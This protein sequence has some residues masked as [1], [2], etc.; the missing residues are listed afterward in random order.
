MRRTARSVLVAVALLLLPG[1]IVA[2]EALFVWPLA[3]PVMK[4]WRAKDNCTLEHVQDG[5]GALRWRTEFGRFNF[6]WTT[7]HLAPKL[8]F[9]DAGAV[10]FKVRGDGSGHF[11]SLQLGYTERGKRS[12]YYVNKADGVV[13]DFAE[14]R[15]VS[16]SLARFSPPTGRD[17]RADMTQVAFIEFFV[18][19]KGKGSRTDLML[20]DV[21]VLKAPPE[22]AAELTQLWGMF[23]EMGRQSPAS[24][25]SNVLPNSGFEVE[26]N[27]DGLPDLWRCGDWNT[28]SKTAWDTDVAH[29]G[30]ASVRITCSTDKQRGSFAFRPV[31]GPGPWLFE[32]HC[33]ADDAMKTD[34]RNGP[35]ARLI[36]VNEKGDQ[37]G[38]FHARGGVGDGQWQKVAVAFEL[39]PGAKHI[40]LD[41]F[42]LFAAGSVWWDDVSLRF[43]TV[44]A[45]RQEEERRL[46]AQRAEEAGGMLEGVTALVTALP[47][48]A[49][50][51]KLKKAALM[52]ALEDA[53][54]SLEA[55]LGTEAVTTLTGLKQ[56]TGRAIGRRVDPPAELMFPMPGLA[57]NPYAQG[58]IGRAASVLRSKTLYKKGD[59]GYSQVS[60]AWSFSTMGNNVYAATWGLCYPESPHAAD[61]ELLIRVLRLLQAIFQNHRDGD[62]NPGREAVHGR[63]PNINRFCFV[64]TFEAYLLLTATYPDLLLP[65]KRAE[66]LA[67]AREA[68][69]HQVRTYG[70]RARNEPPHCYYANMDVHYM[71]ML[72]LAARMFDSPRYHGEAETFC[73]LT[74][75]A[76]YPDG[77]FSYHGFQNECFTYHQINV[78]QLARYWQLTGSELARDTVVKSRPY[79]PYNVEPGG[80]PEYY[81]DCFWKHYWSGISPIGPEIVA[82]M[83]GCA[84][85]RRIALDELRWAKPNH[86]YAIYAGTLYR[87]GIR[88][89]PLPNDFLI[90]DRNVEGPRGRFGRWSFAG[91]TRFLGEGCQGKDTF[92]GGMIVD[93]PNRRFPLNAALQVVT[94]Q[95]RLHP[96]TKS[97]K[98]RRWRECRYLSQEE[99]NAVTVAD[100]FAALS[101]RYRIQNVAWGGKST[102]TEW[103]GDQQWF[104]T[105]HGLYGVLAIEPLTD[106]QAYSIHGRVR[107]GMNKEIERKGD[108]FFKYGGLLCRLHAHNYSDV[109]TEKSETFYIDKPERFRS[110]EIVLRDR[111]IVE[112]GEGALLPYA[113]GTRQF[114]T[115]EVLP[116]WS[117]LAESVRPIASVE[118]VCGLEVCMDGRWLLLAQNTTGEDK[119][120][121]A[122]LPW[123]AA[124][125]VVHRSG[126][127]TSSPVALVAPA[128]AVK[129]DIPAHSHVVLEKVR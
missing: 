79:Y 125:S 52:W 106:Q 127:H 71:L 63:D 66:W 104:L 53:K 57:S 101:T 7:R 8:D 39:P 59:E 26:L 123:A 33:R 10:S 5:E 4:H 62:F 74:A 9:T 91:T 128:G 13:L 50:A 18:E 83:T 98:C 37:C 117:A 28:G 129:V 85:N 17:P 54:A 89:E 78:A 11:L 2:Q 46:E 68:T 69:E 112:G 31:V 86:Y 121:E 19:R 82:G 87:P 94:N 42:N 118:G 34:G 47:E 14:W 48:D 107:F 67:S 12:L 3:Q 76:L 27:Q 16:F 65:S 60:N 80:V 73:K 126:G 38:T 124:G 6:G 97:E 88:D 23:A 24:D 93:E 44:R 21:R 109:I 84:H 55:G 111:G 100:T 92:V 96:R 36:A 113:K 70:I 90:Y 51:G 30:G 95:F 43:D 110:T 32:A 40:N 1:R 114:F 25:G 29:S 99:H 102:L 22:R 122:A 115:V 15:D 49:P 81:T 45:T 61:P 41:L 58:V 108:A 119:V 120:F 116:Y 56:A 35:V 105:P 72:E 103:A 77:A 64:P 20:D 75:D